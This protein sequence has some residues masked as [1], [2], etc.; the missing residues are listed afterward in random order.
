[1]AE[2]S[3]SVPFGLIVGILIIPPALVLKM[4]GYSEFVYPVAVASIAIAFAIRGYW[5]LRSHWWFWV[6][7]IAIVGLHVPLIVFISWNP[8]WVPAPLIMLA[9]V[10]DFGVLLGIIG[11]IDKLVNRH[12]ETKATKGA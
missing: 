4:L 11:L 6:T 5:E 3:T 12:E 8:G 10:V 1:M 9:A 7:V 2:R